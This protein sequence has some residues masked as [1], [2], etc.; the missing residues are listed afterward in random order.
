MDEIEVLRCAAQIEQRIFQKLCDE[1]IKVDL[2]ICE[3]I[4]EKYF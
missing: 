4:C 2:P 1:T 3:I